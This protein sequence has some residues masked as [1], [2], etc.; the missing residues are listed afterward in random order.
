[1][2]VCEPGRFCSSKISIS[3]L[4]L[5]ISLVVVS[6]DVLGLVVTVI[7]SGV[8]GVSLRFWMRSVGNL[9]AGW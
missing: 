8:G 9:Y 7:V 2:S 1:M 4:I 5:R 6:S 3:G